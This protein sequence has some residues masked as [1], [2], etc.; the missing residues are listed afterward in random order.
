M[1]WVCWSR[2]NLMTWDDPERTYTTKVI[3]G[4]KRNSKE[5]T[6]TT[7]IRCTLLPQL[8]L[9]IFHELLVEWVFF[10]NVQVQNLKDSYIYIYYIKYYYF[11]NDNIVILK[12][13]YNHII[14]KINNI[15]RT[16]SKRNF[17]RKIF[18]NHCRV[19][20]V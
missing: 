14:I 11:F 13:N 15:Q 1:P 12:K 20:T 8:S 3:L 17:L 19:L 9:G 10:S 6:W 2:W 5:S 4:F 18:V 16:Q 7:N